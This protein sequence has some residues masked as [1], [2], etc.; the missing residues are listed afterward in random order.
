MLP[1]KTTHIILRLL[2][3]HSSSLE[4]KEERQL[5][6]EFKTKPKYRIK[7]NLK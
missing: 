4:I 7:N 1:I 5:Y 6:N 2:N 3:L